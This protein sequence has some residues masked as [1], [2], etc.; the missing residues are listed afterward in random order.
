MKDILNY[1]CYEVPVRRNSGTKVR[2]LA[3]LKDGFEKIGL[4]CKLWRP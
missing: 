3:Y 1:L 2:L 4:R